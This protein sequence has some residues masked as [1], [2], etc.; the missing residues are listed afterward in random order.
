MRSHISQQET[1]SAA[2]RL[3]EALLAQ[4]HGGLLR[5][6]DRLPTER[7]LSDQF[8]IARTTVRR[9]L[10]ELKS[11]SIITQTVGRGTY[12]AEGATVALSAL[13]VEKPAALTTPK[14]LM[15]ARLTFEPA[16]I[17]M[18]VRRA[19]P[20]DLQR[21]EH[22]CLKAEEASTLEEFEHWDAR[23]HEVIADAA[24]NNLVSSVFRLMN[25]VRT[26]PVWSAVKQRT[27]TPE[28]R[29]EYQ[30]EHR[31]IVAALKS[32]DLARALATTRGHLLHVRRNLLGY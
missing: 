24:H 29:A 3:R 18:V 26:Q 13:A 27:V 6:G 25:L 7:A 9:V 19:T 8:A 10:S 28:R 21:I 23:F 11:L 31:L 20:T 14:E 15:E 4:L 5:P 2:C 16:A 32:R 1:G 30:L 17:A 22:C 12:V